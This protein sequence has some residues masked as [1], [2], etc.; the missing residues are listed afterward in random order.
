M[1]DNESVFLKVTD[2]ATVFQVTDRTV[3]NWI[4]LG[5]PKYQVEKTVRFDL[6]EVREWMKTRGKKV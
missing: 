6:N 3:H 2:L 1:N 4:E 5:C